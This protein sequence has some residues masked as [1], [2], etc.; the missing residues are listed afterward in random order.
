MSDVSRGA[1]REREREEGEGRNKE[2]RSSVNAATRTGTPRREWPAG[3]L[4]LIQSIITRHE[5]SGERE[6]KMA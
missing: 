6:R 4:P 3:F 1:S 2:R 5:S